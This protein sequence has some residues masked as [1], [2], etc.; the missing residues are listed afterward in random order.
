[1]S[2]FKIRACCYGQYNVNLLKHAIFEI[3]IAL[4]NVHRPPILYHGWKEH[5][6]EIYH[7]DPYKV[8]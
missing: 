8:K 6:L 1:M 4:Q 7:P 2:K 5:E 3:E